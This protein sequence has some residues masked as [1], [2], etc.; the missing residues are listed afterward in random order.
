MATTITGSHSSSVTLSL[1]SQNPATVAQGATTSASGSG[2]IGTGATYWT[3]NNYGLVEG[4]IGISLADGGIITNG[5][6]STVTGT[7]YGIEIDNKAGSLIN[8]GLISGTSTL[9]G[10]GVLMTDGGS[11][12]NDAS[13]SIIGKLTGVAIAGAAGKLT[14]SGAITGQNVTVGKGV[15][16]AAG[17]YVSNAAS[18]SITGGQYGVEIFGGA[19]TVVNSGSI[20]STNA[21]TGA[22]VYLKAGGSVTNAASGAITGNAGVEITGVAGTVVN[23]GSIG[24]TSATTGDGVYLRAGGLVTNMASASIAGGKYGVDIN[25][26]VGTVVNSGTISDTNANSGVGVYLKAGGFATNA[27][28]GIISGHI[29]LEIAGGFGTLVNSGAIGTTATPTGTGVMLEAGGYVTNA[30]SASITGSADGIVISGGAGTILNSGTIGGALTIVNT[31]VSSGTTSASTSISGAAVLLSNGG[32]VTNAASAVITGGQYGIELANGRG[33][34][35]NFGTIGQTSGTAVY[36]KN[37]SSFTNNATGLVTATGH[38]VLLQTGGNVLNS[39]RIVGGTYAVQLVAAGTV[40]NSGTVSATNATSGAG[41][42]LKSGGTVTNQAHGLIR[43]THYGV[44]A[45]DT[46]TVTNAASASINGGRI[47]IDIL[48]NG[49]VLNSGNVI[50]SGGTSD[51]GIYL[52]SGYV[53]NALHA[54][55]DGGV[56]FSSAAATGAS[57][58]TLVNSG[59]I[60]ALYPPGPKY[61]VAFHQSGTFT[62]AASGLI[63]AHGYGVLLGNGGSVLNSGTIVGGSG[64][65]IG[66]GV[67]LKAGG[68]VA[69]NA[70][71]AIKGVIGIDLLAGGTVTNAGTIA[72]T[73]G[74]AIAFYGTASGQL[75][76][77]AGAVFSGAVIGS[78]SA[79]NALELAAGGVGTL[80]GIGTNFVNFGNVT[81]DSSAHWELTGSNAL[82]ANSTLTN[83]GTLTLS[84]ATLSDAGSVI[85]NG[86]IDLDPSTM[87]V[88]NLNGAGTVTIDAGSTLAVQGTV[89]SGQ[90][91]VFSG[92]GAELDLGAPSSFSNTLTGFV[93]GDKIGLTSV[94]N[95]AGGR[96]DMDYSTN[97]LTVTEGGAPYHFQ[98]DKNQIF[99]GDFFHLASQGGGTVITADQ[100]ACYRRGTRIATKAGETPVEELSIGDE[101]MTAS[102]VARPIKWIGRRSY[103]GRFIIGRK[104]ILPICFKVGSLG[105]GLPRRDLWISPHHA[106][107][108][109]RVLIEA[110][111]LVNGVSIVQADEVDSVEYF[112]IELDSHD[113]ILA[114]GAPSE[115]FVDDDSRGMFH[116]VQEYALL[117]PD[118]AERPTRYCAPR[119]DEGF[120]VDAVRRRLALRAGL[121]IG[122]DS[123]A[124]RGSVDVVSAH[125]I[126]GWAQNLRHPEA[127]VC[128]DV[129]AD[130]SLIGQT[131]ANRHRGDLE[132][133]GIG[134][135]RHA[136]VFTPPDGIAFPPGAIE[137]RRSLDGAPLERPGAAC[138]A[139][140]AAG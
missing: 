40:V 54:T 58:G 96:A 3:I 5:T 44:H 75:I 38:G 107:Y 82:T 66:S 91:I 111:D 93:A 95:V 29:G 32:N 50:G 25:G 63:T 59:A 1:A 124:L 89:S 103:G 100:I 23:Y 73:G 41:V 86:T 113:V 115:T 128:L 12:R 17:G 97:V 79:A 14:N 101:I 108:L 67:D 77:D 24:T 102:G 135:G 35:F 94:A 90:H 109:D 129:Y 116:N 53:L 15:V 136:F 88:A 46:T 19:G 21:T 106:M 28:S 132:T 16:L 112:H 126:E 2:L 62:N 39:G 131:L 65:T 6:S 61:G 11:V 121:A 10:T 47:G 122:P 13:G 49:T 51:S 83:N 36:V 42:D 31:I 138:H 118:E 45:A 98:F 137:V 8:G 123:G 72:G 120:V 81:V 133:A 80:S 30:A 104:D 20:S 125:A 9:V 119:L 92:S 71:A 22:G 34:V 87:T 99:N 18:A 43:G 57:A 27:A 78:A 56:N 76:V 105:E 84:G 4:T 114:E 127:P 110:K 117:Y 74:K 33:A 70:S 140:A 130:G 60:R 68:S 37:G 134:N 7:N 26:G 69:N 64:N 139:L 48:A 85:N 52:K 55:I